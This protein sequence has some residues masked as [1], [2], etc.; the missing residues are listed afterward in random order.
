MG[1]MEDARLLRRISI[2]IIVFL[3]LLCAGT[4]HTLD[5]ESLKPSQEDIEK[6]KKYESLKGQKVDEKAKER[7][8]L[9]ENI[10][11]DKVQEI[12]RPDVKSSKNSLAGELSS[13]GKREAYLFYL[14]SK[15][16]PQS[17][18]DSI[19]G[20]AKKLKGVNFYG[21]LRGIDSKRDVLKAVRETKNFGGITIKVN[22]LIFRFVG[23]SMVP[24]FVYAQCPPK[25]MFRSKE[26]DFKLV[27]YGDMTLMG[28]LS[29]MA[30]KD[31]DIEGIYAD[32]KNSF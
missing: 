23:A 1:S 22:P 15:S 25:V 5:M 26:C 20:Q 31:K 16:V 30:E 14:F 29:M 18:V 11:L 27:I 19:F 4:S 32:L 28:A 12:T 9:K 13:P 2:S 6:A 24:A 7:E 17:A 3:A 8:A 10:N 21:V